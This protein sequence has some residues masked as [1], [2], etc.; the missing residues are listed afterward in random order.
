MSRFIL[1]RLL[2]ACIVM[3]GVASLVFLLLHLVPGDPVDVMLGEAATVADREALRRQLGLDAP[4]LWQWSSYLI[5]LLHLDLGVSIHTHQPVASLLARRIPATVILAVTAFLVSLC[6]AFPLGVGAALKRGR[7][8]DRIAM[9]FSVTGVS[10]PNFWLG[11]LL[12]LL[13][14]YWLGWLP[15]SGMDGWPSLVLPALTLGTTLA[16][17]Q[18]RMIR[19]SLLEVMNE[20]YIR[21]ARARGLGERTVILQHGLRNALLPVVTVMGIQLGALLTG[22]VIT[23]FIFDWPGV[24][25]L[26]I[27]AIHKRDYPVVQGCILFISAAYVAI[28]L[29]TDITYAWLDPRIRL[30]E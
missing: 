2:T 7:A 19:A 23:E 25:Q 6:I 30:H 8:A 28:N 5:G 12:I 10:I 18:S 16:A 17:L 14:S 3:L 27:E 20:D 29:L 15:V 24:G 22:A 26:T 11:P 4:L 21:A 9:L 13:F 1:A